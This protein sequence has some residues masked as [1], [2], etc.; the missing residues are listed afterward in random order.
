MDT[1]DATQHRRSDFARLARHLC[2]K[3]IGLVLGGGGARGISQVGVIRALEEAGIPIDIVGGTSIGAFNAGL[4]AKDADSVPIYGRAKKFAG[5][6][7]S[8]WRLATDLT[9]PTTSYTTGHE[10]NRGIWKTFGDTHIEDFW[11]SYYCNSANIL[12]FR[13][14]IHTTGYAW[15]YIRASMTLTGFLPPMTDE[16]GN[17]LVDG[18]Y[19]DNLTVAAMKDMGADVIFAVDV[20]SVNDNTPQQYGDS[21]SGVWALFNHYNPF[22][23]IPDVPTLSDIQSRLAY[24]TSVPALEKAKASPGVLYMQP[25]VQQYGT[26]DFGKFDEIYEVGYRYC[27]EFLEGLRKEGKLDSLVIGSL[28]GPGDR[29]RSAPRLSRRQSI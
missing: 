29:R 25:P 16:E 14:E 17:M 19:M 18:G 20:G 27:K 5:R 4:Y 12:K 11:L 8:L 10:F 22:S 21:L 24:A 6:M 15:R 2:G 3:S 7:A 23:K 1:D 28:K 26:L 13:M 9:W